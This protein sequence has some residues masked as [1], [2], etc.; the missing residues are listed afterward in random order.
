MAQSYGSLGKHS[1]A[2]SCLWKALRI[3]EQVFPENHLSISGISSKLSVTYFEL[4]DCPPALLHAKKAMDI[5]ECL[6]PPTHLQLSIVYNNIGLIY[7]TI[8]KITQ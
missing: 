5:E 4:R 2:L 6:L 3:Q 7:K 8:W 1:D